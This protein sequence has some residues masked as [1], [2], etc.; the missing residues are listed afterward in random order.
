MVVVGLFFMVAMVVEGLFQLF[1]L[2]HHL[3]LVG[4]GGEE[5]QLQ[6][7]SLPTLPQPPRDA[8]SAQPNFK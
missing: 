1:Q 2:F 6:G 8:C 3:E 5:L 4:D 7:P